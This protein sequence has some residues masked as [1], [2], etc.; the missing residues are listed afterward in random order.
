MDESSSLLTKGT[1]PG[2]HTE[3]IGADF[4]SYMVRQIEEEYEAYKANANPGANKAAGSVRAS[5]PAQN[6]LRNQRTLKDFDFN[7]VNVKPRRY[8][9]SWDFTL[10]QAAEDPSC[11]VRKVDVADWPAMQLKPVGAQS[12]HDQKRQGDLKNLVI[13]QIKVKQIQTT[14]TE[15]LCLQIDGIKGNNY[16]L[17]SGVRTP[18]TI[19]PESNAYG[20]DEVI[21]RLDPA[22][23]KMADLKYS[24]MSR[25]YLEAQAPALPNTPDLCAVAVNSDLT[26][27]LA[28]Q[29]NPLVPKLSQIPV[30][31]EGRNYVLTRKLANSC[32]DRLLKKRG[33]LKLPTTNGYD[34][35]LAL[36]KANGEKWDST[37]VAKR[38]SEQTGLVGQELLDLP[39]KTTMVIEMEFFIISDTWDQKPATPQ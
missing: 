27:V 26:E 13:K 32:I 36:V 24:K 11:T 16:V 29:K 2:P 38:V 20:V 37:D 30:F 6:S 7:D 18:F 4:D 14:S 28:S 12:E 15:A 22:L 8:T 21:H 23:M 31:N 1:N 3:A 39:I 9:V 33:D 25:E 5:A 35:K 17:G 10:N 19:N 34:L